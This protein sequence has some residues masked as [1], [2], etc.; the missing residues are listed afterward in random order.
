MEVEAKRNLRIFGISGSPR[1]GST[2]YAVRAAL[3]YSKEKYL[4]ETEYFSCHNK[5]LKFCIHCDYCVKKRKGCVHKD[6]M[7]EVYDKLEWADVIIIGTPVYQ[8]TLSGQTKVIMD[9][10]RAIVAKDPGILKN[11]VGASIAV[12]GD[13]VGGQELAIQSVLNFY[14]I[15]EMI[16]VGGGSFGANMGITFWSK[17][18][19]AEGVKEDS[20]GFK[21][22]YKTVDRIM[23][24]ATALDGGLL[25]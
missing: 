5:T 17:D 15:S 19:L 21:S 10:C 2:D 14:L 8:G 18:K 23:S 12:G 9:R 25:R 6:D 24:V 22:L 16:P 20:E 1:I 7:Q 3:D 11:K 13:R 4:T